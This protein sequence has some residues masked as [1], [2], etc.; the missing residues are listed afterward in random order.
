MRGVILYGPPAAGKDTITRA[1]RDLDPA[2]R[3][4]QRLKAGPGRTAGYR[5]TTVEHIDQ[6]R[7]AGDVVWE[8][9]RYGAVY[10]VDRPTLEADLIDHIPVL[11]LG[12]VDAVQAVRSSL[13]DVHWLTVYVHC[14]RNIARNRITARATGD[15]AARLRAWDETAP[16]PDASLAIDTGTTSP[17]DA[18][19]R[20]CE[21]LAQLAV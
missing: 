3:L 15:T 9:H 2:C 13:P 10:V 12:Q 1:L 17:A 4:F 21:H 16:L 11:H 6:L 8:N 14:A 5:M 7:A 19:R 18:A 20:I